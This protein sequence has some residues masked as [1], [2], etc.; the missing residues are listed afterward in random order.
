MLTLK[1]NQLLGYFSYYLVGEAYE[2]W[3]CLDYN[4][5]LKFT[6][7]EVEKIQIEHNK[8]EDNH[9]H[10]KEGKGKKKMKLQSL[11]MISVERKLDKK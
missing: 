2:W 8:K 4:K 7:E 5:H 6:W 11:I 9:D 3:W 1:K 10:R